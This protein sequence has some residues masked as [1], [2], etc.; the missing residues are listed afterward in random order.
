MNRNDG[1]MGLP[2]MPESASGIPAPAA[3]AQPTQFNWSA[4]TEIVP[5]PSKGRFYPPT[6][7]LHNAETVEIKYMTAKEEDILTS[8]SLL[9]EGLAVDRALQ[10]LIIDTNVRVTD[11]LVG[12]KNALVIASRITGY[13]EE[14]E[15]SVNCPQCSATTRHTFDLSELDS[16]DFESSMQE[17]GITIS[18][19][20]TFT[21]TL[22]FSKLTVECRLLTGKDENKMF[23]N[24][25]RNSKKKESSVFTDQLRSIIV[26]INGSSNALE[27]GSLVNELPARDARY[28][29]TVFGSVSPNID[30][31]QHFECSECDY[32]ADMEVPLT[33]D[34][35]WPR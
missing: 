33:A 5:L 16:V 32:A 6:H 29:R 1:R 8:Q 30:M 14:Y 24:A 27:V 11:L 31:S 9:K 2:E 7:P 15:T 25:Q 28:L 21:I 23:K 34:F 3:E 17:H 4:P 10:S 19:N 35:L 18:E 12:D 20:N 22:P 13:G 26:S